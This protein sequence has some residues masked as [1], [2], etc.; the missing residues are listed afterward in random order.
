MKCAAWANQREEKNGEQLLG[1]LGLV[2]VLNG[3]KGC[4]TEQIEINVFYS[5]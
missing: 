1:L 4:K 5:F 2:N 3:A